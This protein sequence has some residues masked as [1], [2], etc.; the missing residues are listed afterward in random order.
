MKRLLISMLTIGAVVSA[1]CEKGTEPA[2][3][4]KAVTKVQSVTL[5]VPIVFATNLPGVGTTIKWI[6]ERIEL[7]SNGSV[8]MKIYEPGKLVPPFEILDAVSTGKVNAGYAAAAYWTGKIP[9][10]SLFTAIPFGPEAGEYLAWLWYGNGGKLYQE[11]YDQAGYNVKVL[12]CGI[13]A[14]ETGGWFAK[15]INTAEDLKGLSM[16]FGGLGGQVMERL[17]VSISLLPPAEIFPALEKRAID[18]T[19]LS[20][21]AIDERLGFHKVVKYNYFPGWHQQAS[22]PELLINK[23]TWNAMSEGQQ[24]IIDVMCRAATAD[25]FAYS[26]AIQFDVMKRNVE[27]RGVIIKYWPE[28]ILT[29]YE[30]IWNEVAEENARNDA[31]FKKVWNDLKVFRAKYDIWEANAFLPRAKGQK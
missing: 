17:G 21:P 14:P 3:E 4:E 18:A 29:L 31:F 9:A 11:M 20:M 16:R 6:A 23:A 8:T 26:E 15:P 30:K 5:K 13:I 28:E 7:V 10:S 24:M 19:E 12:P 25:S 1:A 27:E 22:V 2:T